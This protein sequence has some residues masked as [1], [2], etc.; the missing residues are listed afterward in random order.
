MKVLGIDSSSGAGSCALWEDGALIAQCY[1]H[2]KLTHSQTL[3][4]MVEQLLSNTA[5]TPDQIDG[6]AVTVGPGSFTGLRIG[7]ATVKGMAFGTDK[8]C[9]GLS[10]LEMLA[11][12]VTT[13]EGIICATMDARC[14][15][16]Y[17]ASFLSD[18]KG[19]VT[20]MCDDTAMAVQDLSQWILAQDKAVMLVGDGAVLC[21]EQMGKPDNVRVAPSTQRYGQASALLLALHSRRED[22]PAVSP[23]E[24][25]PSYLRLPQAERERL[26][27]AISKQ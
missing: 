26:K 14:A 7:I 11:Y 25:A 24:L 16:V 20:R 23:S 27:R 6:F 21:H 13:H 9:Y 10:T 22:I 19:A 12:G 17:T 18:G 4:P 5:C 15:Q 1:L 2:N 3:M 8:P